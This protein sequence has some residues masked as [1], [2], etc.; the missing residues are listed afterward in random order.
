MP[1]IPQ[2]KTVI[3]RLRGRWKLYFIYLC[4][5]FVFLLLAQINLDITI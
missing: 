1:I 5:Y 4:L 2:Q 3:D